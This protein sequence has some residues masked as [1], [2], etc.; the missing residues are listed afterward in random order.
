MCG[1]SQ[2]GRKLA[3]SRVLPNVLSIDEQKSLLGVF[4]QRYHSGRKNRLMVELMLTAGFRVSEICSL[5]W[6][7]LRYRDNKIMIKE[8]KGKKDRNIF[9]PESLMLKIKAYKEDAPE[10]VYV[11]ATR[12]GKPQNRSTLN[13]M[14]KTYSG[15]AGIE[16]NVYN[17]LL[18][19]TA[20]TD[21][22]SKTKDIRKVQQI[23]GHS[24]IQTTMIYT[25]ISAE[26]IKE[27]MTE[28]KY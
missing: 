19:H 5:R 7:D 4:N 23:A 21:L 10:S 26:D 17:H 3:K 13:E 2:K 27:T 15:K 12:T 6:I 8:A 14:I 22:Y 18:R 28:E 24:N 1:Y 20:L 11:F 16:K 25:H 9:I